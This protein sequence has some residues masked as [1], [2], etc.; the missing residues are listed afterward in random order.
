LGLNFTVDIENVENVALDIF[1]S[2]PRSL[3]DGHAGFSV[4]AGVHVLNLVLNLLNLV[5]NLVLQSAVASVLQY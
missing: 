2:Y 3:V 5:L 1:V 4:F